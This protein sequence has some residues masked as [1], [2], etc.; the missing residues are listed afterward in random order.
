M[1]QDA[2]PSHAP[3]LAAI[4]AA[5]FDGADAW[6][7]DSFAT[8]LSTPGTTGLIDVRGGFIL[9]R[10]AADQ[11]DVVT[12]AVLPE[13]RRQGLAT[14]LLEHALA[15]L[16]RQAVADV[17]L[18]VAGANAAAAGLYR[19]LGFTAAGKRRAYYADGG[20]A[21]LMRRMLSDSAA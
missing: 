16:R 15:L 10:R 11:A 12:L 6:S 4:H 3:V 17:F 9:L 2:T 8:L 18:E 7:A 1:I 20:D 14:A 21:V 13:M 5:C 19:K